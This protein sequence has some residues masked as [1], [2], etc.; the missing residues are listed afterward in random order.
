MVG[1]NRFKES[2]M[3]KIAVAG[4]VA[5]LMATVSVCQAQDVPKMPGPE[6]EHEWLQQLAGEWDADAEAFMEPGKPPMKCKG[7]E[8][9]RSIGGFWIVAETKSTMMGM[10]FT[11]CLTIGYDPQKER[12]LGT[13]IDSMTSYLWKYEG[14]VDSAGKILTLETEGPCPASPGKLIKFK[15]VLEIKDKDHKRFTSS[16]QGE[17]GKWT[18]IMTINYRRKK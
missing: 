14:T 18:T 10:P 17:D 15:E 13:W 8:S 4:L 2:M 9:I 11:G 1:K 12:Y 16:M 6:Q 7:T 5:A 3:R